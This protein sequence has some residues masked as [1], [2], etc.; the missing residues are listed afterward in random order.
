MNS[1]DD[2][3]AHY[4]SLANVLKQ[5]KQDTTDKDSKLAQLRTTLLQIDNM[6][7]EDNL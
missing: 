7:D 5:A 1:L 3:I 4:E 6:I 2:L